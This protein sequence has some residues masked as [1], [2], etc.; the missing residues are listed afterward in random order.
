MKPDDAQSTKEG[1]GMDQL[2]EAFQ[3]A[4]NDLYEANI[5]VEICKEFNHKNDRLG[6]EPID[7]Q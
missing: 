2:R 1:T 5:A 6:G 7:Q 4:S 3:L